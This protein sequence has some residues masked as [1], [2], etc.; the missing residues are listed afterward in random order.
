MSPYTAVSLLLYCAGTSATPPSLPLLPPGTAMSPEDSRTAWRAG[1]AAAGTTGTTGSGR[2]TG[3]ARNSPGQASPNPAACKPLV[4]VVGFNAVAFESLAGA[5][6]TRSNLT[7]PAPAPTGVI[8]AAE[9]LTSNWEGGSGGPSQTKSALEA[10]SVA[11]S[12]SNLDSLQLLPQSGAA[13]SLHLKDAPTIIKQ[14]AVQVDSGNDGS[15]SLWKD[16]VVPPVHQAVLDTQQ[17]YSVTGGPSGVTRDVFGTSLPGGWLSWLHGNAAAGADS[18][19]TTAT[20]GAAAGGGGGIGSHAASGNG[21]GGASTSNSKPLPNQLLSQQQQAS[22]AAWQFGLRSGRNRNEGS[23]QLRGASVDLPVGYGAYTLGLMGS[24][25]SQP[26]PVTSGTQPVAAASGDTNNNNSALG[27]ASGVSSTPITLSTAA[28]AGPPAGVPRPMTAAAAAAGA[29]AAGRRNWGKGLMGG[30]ARLTQYSAPSTAG[31]GGVPPVAVGG[32]SSGRRYS[33]G[34]VSRS[35]PPPQALHQQQYSGSRSYKQYP[36][37]NPP[38]LH[39]Q[40][41]LGVPAAALSG[42]CE[43][44]DGIAQGGTGVVPKAVQQEKAPYRLP[45]LHLPDFL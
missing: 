31:E 33:E 40:G 42:A 18:S 25:F 19:S 38:W 28:A 34:H 39:Q 36:H 22:T 10:L 24:H 6:G 21:S 3:T 12:L 2:T 14:P 27:T 45:S 13:Q 20:T 4:S 32:T 16:L 7:L 8:E 11:P 9:G 29:A 15:A 17:Q 1:I 30:G 43:G 44:A 35:G 5:V 23:G 37:Y 41:S 26:P